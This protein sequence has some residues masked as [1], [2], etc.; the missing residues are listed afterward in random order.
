MVEKN[1]KENDCKEIYLDIIEKE[2]SNGLSDEV[3]KPLLKLCMN[4]QLC[5]LQVFHIMVRA[6]CAAMPLLKL[7]R[8]LQMD[9]LPQKHARR[10]SVVEKVE[11]A[12]APSS[13]SRV[14]ERPW[15]KFAT[16][17]CQTQYQAVRD[18][19]SL[20]RLDAQSASFALERC[21]IELAA[22]ATASHAFS[23]MCQTSHV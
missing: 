10:T 2:K 7:C 19:Q 21:S 13:S 20:L 4:S 6:T 23:R 5:G 12:R 1:L 22:K 17:N 16:Q 3:S 9:A 8:D 18:G 11:P 15:R 14:Q